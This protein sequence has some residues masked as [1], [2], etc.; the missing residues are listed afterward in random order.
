MLAPVI[1]TAKEPPA[2]APPK[3]TALPSFGHVV[4]VVASVV[5][6][7]EVATSQ[8]PLP[9]V[10]PPSFAGFHVYVALESALTAHPITLMI[11]ETRMNCFLRTFVDVFV[12][13]FFRFRRRLRRES[14]R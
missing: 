9:A 11:D 10:A 3:T 8:A 2:L 12:N 6:F 7:A 13:S 5:Q 14:F 4:A 1:V